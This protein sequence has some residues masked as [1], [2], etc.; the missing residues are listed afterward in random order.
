MGLNIEQDNGL[1][2]VFYFNKT[3][4]VPVYNK[5]TLEKILNSDY[6]LQVLVGENKIYRSF[7]V[8]MK[9]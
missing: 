4:T 8:K 9:C 1:D 5:F 2:N 6:N 7:E 3:I